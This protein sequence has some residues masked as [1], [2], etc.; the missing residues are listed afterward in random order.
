MA[1]LPHVVRLEALSVCT[2]CS[3]NFLPQFAVNNLPHEKAPTSPCQHPEL[4][5]ASG[6]IG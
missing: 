1:L 2:P 5:A 4:A 6:K 3:I